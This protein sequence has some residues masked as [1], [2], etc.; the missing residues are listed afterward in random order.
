MTQ[1][2][3]SQRRHWLTRTLVPL[4]L[5]IASANAKCIPL[6]GSTACPQFASLQVD[7]TAAATQTGQDMGFTIANFDDLAQF[8][9]AIQ[10][11]TGWYTSPISCPGYNKTEHIRYQ[12]TVACALMTQDVASVACS[13]TATALSMCRTTCTEYATSLMQMVTKSCSSDPESNRMAIELQNK[14]C[15]AGNS[16]PGLS[17]ADAATCVNGSNNE[18]VTCGFVNQQ[19]MCTFCGNATNAAD[20]CCIKNSGLCKPVTTTTTTVITT[21]GNTPPAST[22]TTPIANQDD[23]DKKDGVIAG[24]STAALGGIIGGGV[25]LILLF[26]AFIVCC[27]RRN[28]S[29]NGKGGNKVHGHGGN[30]GANNL[31]RHMSNSSAS[32]YK[33]SSPKLQEEGFSTGQVPSAPIPMTALPSLNVQSVAA[34]AVAG[35]AA[36]NRISKASSIG[37]ASAAGGAEGKQYCQALYPYQAS[38]ADELDLSPGDIVNVHKV[39]DDGWAVG[40]N[41]NTSNEGA[42]P[43][44]CVMFVDEAALHD[45]FED[46]NMHSMT[47]MGLREDDNGRSGSPRSSLPSRASSPVHLP[48]RQ[49]SMI[50]DSVVIPGLSN[51]GRSSPLAGSPLAGGNH[52]G[53]K[54][55]PPVRDTMMSDASSINRWWDGEGK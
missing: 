6:T 53:S 8:D 33:I 17:S 12:N 23:G 25:V 26:F 43:V 34:A 32:K 5:L 40:V 16:Y 2:P 51:G 22:P 31:S 38:M 1:A 14:V 4:A 39:F 18:D 15:A 45:D 10:A 36:A 7:T 44:V 13:S 52:P 30:A 27:M 19:A 29:N 54:L 46:V 9:K 41:M 28:R 20:T 50:R 24:L 35:G 3:S 37:G 42:F 49:S 48:R 21:I 11:S 55:Q 47:P